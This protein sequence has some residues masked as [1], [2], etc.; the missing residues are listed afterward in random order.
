MLVVAP[1]PAPPTAPSDGGVGDVCGNGVE[2]QY[3]TVQDNTYLL[4][5]EK[6]TSITLE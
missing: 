1:P 6:G 3:I 2:F 5:K 4:V